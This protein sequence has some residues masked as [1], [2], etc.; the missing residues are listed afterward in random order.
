MTVSS[1]IKGGH[2]GLSVS[3]VLEKKRDLIDDGSTNL[4]HSRLDSLDSLGSPVLVPSSER[5]VASCQR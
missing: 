1:N 4:A 5:E 2:L 3:G